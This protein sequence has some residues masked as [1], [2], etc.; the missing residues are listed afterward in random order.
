MESRDV[1][2]KGQDGIQL[3]LTLF[4]KKEFDDKIE[5][6]LHD[7]KMDV[8]HF[9]NGKM[10]LAAAKDPEYAKILSDDCELLPGEA[11]LFSKEVIRK[12]R[13]SYIVD[14]R[15]L[16]SLLI[17]KRSGIRSVYLIGDNKKKMHGFMEC[18]NASNPDITFAGAYFMD[19]S[20]SDQMKLS[21]ELIVN[22]I[23]GA[24]TDLVIVMMEV[25]RQAVWIR[26][27]RTIVH[28]KMCV[29]IGAVADCFIKRYRQAPRFF[30]VLHLERLYHRMICHERITQCIR[31]RILYK[32][33]GNT[34][35]K[36]N[37][38]ET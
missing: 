21:D 10:L 27:N 2:S 12:L 29:G 35:G 3:L 6:Y 22:E 7:D 8:L 32:R 25:P 28:S 24:D 34:K 4:S 5:E 14:Y 33:L 18:L 15:A 9:V 13:S 37:E 23:N 16:E 11:S 38:K 31:R 26:E 19:P 30:E 20:V 17:E 1:L 36:E